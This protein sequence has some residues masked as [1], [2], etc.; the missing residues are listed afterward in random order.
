MRVTYGATRLHL[1]RQSLLA[2]RADAGQV[3][4][5]SASVWDI[6]VEEGEGVRCKASKGEVPYSIK[7]AKCSERLID[8]A[9]EQDNGERCIKNL[10]E[11][12]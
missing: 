3:S 10:L 9:V 4:L 7:S 8:S 1:H 11:A 5:W 6:L 12:Q 2:S